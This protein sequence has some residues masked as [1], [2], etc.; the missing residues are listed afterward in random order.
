MSDCVFCKIV[1]KE[2][3]ASIVYEDDVALAFKD[4]E[5]QAPVHVLIVPK[6]HIKSLTDT[7][8]EDKETISHIMV[9][10]IPELAKEFKIVD[11]GFRTVIN[12]G[13]EGGQTVAHLHFHL[14]GGRSM[15]WPPG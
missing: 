5:P 2:I 3:P 11:N 7:T 6:K 15:Q 1:S 12:T 10:V 13:V 8:L 14:I 9:D 4:L